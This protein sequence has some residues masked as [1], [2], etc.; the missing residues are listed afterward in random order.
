MLIKHSGGKIT[1]ALKAATELGTIEY[2]EPEKTKPNDIE[3]QQP[4]N[5]TNHVAAKEI[6]P[7][8]EDT[9]LFECFNNCWKGK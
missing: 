2:S 5:S 7:A 3:E 1:S 8:K 9:S 4:E 6:P